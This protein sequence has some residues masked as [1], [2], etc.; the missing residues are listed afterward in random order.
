[1]ASGRVPN[2]K[3]TFVL[4]DIH[5]PSLAT[6]RV[7]HAAIRARQATLARSP[8]TGIRQRPRNVSTRT[9]VRPCLMLFPITCGCTLPPSE[10]AKSE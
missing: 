3:S 5:Q 10:Q 7:I 8:V 4:F 1:M 6:T 9:S 2:T